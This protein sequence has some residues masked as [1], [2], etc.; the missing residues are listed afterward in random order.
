MTSILS[1]I[2][3]EPGDLRSSAK[4]FGVL[5]CFLIFAPAC[6]AI[7]QARYVENTPGKGDFNIAAPKS[8][9]NIYVDGDDFTGVIRAVGDL[10]AD[11]GRV[12]DSTAAIV[13]DPS[14]LGSHAIIVGTIGKSRVIDQL[15]HD[16]KID[17]SQIAG[18]WESFFLQVVSQ[19]LPGVADALVIVG[20][21]KR[22]TIFGVYDLSEQMGVSPWYWWADVPVVHQDSV[23]V[24]AG[25]YVQ[26]PPAVRYRGI[27]LNDEAPSLSRWAGEKY[28]GF[29]H[30][31]YEKIFELLLRMKGN[32]LWP[33]MW[34]S[35]FN[36]DDPLDA[37]LAD[38]Y[39]VVMGTSHHEPMLRA[40]QEWKRHGKGPWNYATNGDELRAFWDEGVNRN[41]DFESII[42]IGMRGD[43]D[44]PMVEGGDMAANVSLLEQI[45]ADQR[46]IIANRV[47]PDLS[48]VP[49]LWALYKE[50]QE[51]YEKGM[52]VPDDV[53]LLWCDDN[54]GN[55]RRL[56]T[57]AER[58]RSGGAGIYYHFD[59]VGGPRN[60]KWN[61][62]NPISKVWEQMNLAYN[63]GAKD[64]W[65]VNV[66]SLKC[67]EFPIEY[68]LNLAWDPSKWTNDNNLEYTRM[69]AEREFGWEHAGEIADLIATYT[70]Y[71]GRCKP[72]LLSPDTFSPVNYD[73]ADRV[74]ADF[75]TLVD[76]AEAIQAKLPDNAKDAFYELVLYPAKAYATVADLYIAVGKNRLYASQ[77]R[78]SANDL[79][80]QARALFKADQE[81][82]NYYNHELLG[83][84]WNHMMDQTRIGYRGWQQPTR[85][86]MP[87][88]TTIDVP[89]E[90]KMGVT[91]EG[92]ALAWPGAAGKP[93][94]AEMDAFNRQSRFIDVFNRGKTAFPFNAKAVEPWIV[95]SQ[96]Q[97]TVDRDLRLLVS[98]DWSKA[99]AGSMS[100]NV[101]ISGPNADLVTV[102]V[103]AVNPTEVNKDNLDGFV[104]TDGYVSI[105]PEH[106]T[107]KVDSASARWDRI[108]DYGK[109]LSAMTV[110]PNTAP[111]V[112]PPEGSPCL[113]YKMYLA[114]S[115]PVDVF[116]MIAPTQAFVPGRGLRFAVSFDDQQ[117]VVVDA[118]ANMTQ[119]D[120]EHMVSNNI[121]VV[122]SKLTVA[123][124]GYHVLKFWM[125]D[126]AVVLEKIVV[127]L[128][129]VKPSYLGPPESFHRIGAKVGG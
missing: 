60:Y 39:G 10:Q 76:K 62:T 112:T 67:K 32:Y 29:K 71:N 107:A 77:G 83:G 17:P 127:G 91:V 33:A 40:Q 75:K 19:P 37:K 66:G 68:F 99:P 43:G 111:S 129:G 54:W 98:V 64:I 34:G 24:K 38:E 78:A 96:T 116:A 82:S 104:E 36:E 84:K 61:N 125:V 90:A 95:L 8:A 114:D 120:W 58:A 117:P 21:D 101:I 92:S 93:V 123:K 69:W 51:Y 128:G 79:A 28:G 50:V 6:F 109:S 15:I 121:H 110:F 57:E 14:S 106:F 48:K 22:G 49:Q 52:R 5:L 63:Y 42:T 2:V 45:V 86:V 26:G 115:G 3:S 16:G 108:E 4:C 74:A 53:T 13:H 103:N 55:I 18:K 46:K 94:L 11:I 89:S 56:P 23:F 65:I 72:E 12:T 122:Q 7:G 105:E 97:G 73:E 87:K 35:A 41:K 25:K 118:L 20:S 88:V 59:Y 113:Q 80:E 9:A 47:N 81:M 44:M 102:T 126:P 100:G 85:N 119:R 27:F 124:S 1:G 70:K 31:F 30:G